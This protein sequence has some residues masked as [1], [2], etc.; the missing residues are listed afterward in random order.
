MRKTIHNLCRSAIC[1]VLVLAFTAAG[2]GALA[3]ELAPCGRAVGI[4]IKAGGLL[5]CALSDVEGGVCPARSA[6]ILPGDLITG[7]N[8]ADTAT[9]DDFLAAITGAEGGTLE[10]SIQRGDEEK[11]VSVT[12]CNDGS[13]A[14]KLG[15]W[16]REGCTG[17]GT[18]TFID[19]QTGAYGALG[20]PVNDAD[21]G[22]PVPVEDG[23][24]MQAQIESVRRGERGSPG[25]LC[26]VYDEGS[27]LGSIDSNTASGIFGT[28]DTAALGALDAIPVA[29]ESEIQI[30]SAE[31]LSNVCGNTVDSYEVQIT[32][33]YSGDS[34]G[35]AVML[36]VTDPALLEATGGI[37]QG[38]SGSPIIQNGKLIGAVTHVL[39]D[40][41]TRGY[42]VSIAAML[43]SMET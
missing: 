37:V 41:P 8:G 20:H 30:G 10:L 16:L 14:P 27:V 9:T 7:V 13:G 19:P 25:E 31:I 24:I 29:E 21:S 38:M 17:I 18:V 26:G 39:V 22:V 15:L 35:R 1:L 4:S 6:G 12:P 2:S 43:D 40:D 23:S 11:T 28:V 42:G 33:V 36:Q 5:V 32:R 34:A 3:L